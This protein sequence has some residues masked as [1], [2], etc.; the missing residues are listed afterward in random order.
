MSDGAVQARAEA[1]RRYPEGWDSCNEEPVDDWGYSGCQREAFCAGVEWADASPYSTPEALVAAYEEGQR[2]AVDK[3]LA[4]T[5][6]TSAQLH[7]VAWMLQNLPEDKIAAMLP[8]LL[9]IEV[10][11]D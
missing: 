5:R 9:G 7:H 1:W 2:D 6:V 3:G 11:D 8:G 10:R 4:R